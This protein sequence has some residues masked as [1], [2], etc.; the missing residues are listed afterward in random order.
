MND[1]EVTIEQA[2]ARLSVSPD[3]RVLTRIGEFADKDVMPAR[4]I[5]V[6]VLDTESTGSDAGK[7]KL[8]ELGMISMV[9][10]LGTGEICKLIDV[11]DELEDPGMPIS[12]EATAVN[13]ITND[14]V[15]GK[16]I[17]DADVERFMDGVSMVVAHNAEFDRTLV[18]KRFPL[19]KQVRWAC[20]LT[21]VD[22]AAA[23]FGSAKLEMLNL[24]IGKFYDAHRAK[25]DC[26][27]L[28]E[29]L[30]YRNDVVMPVSPMATLISVAQK[31]SF[32]I[33]AVGAPFEVKDE[34]KK[35]GYKWDA[36]KKKVW[37]K[38]VLGF[39][40][41]GAECRWLKQEIYL[42]HDVVVPITTYTSRNLF[43]DRSD[44]TERRS[45]SAMIDQYC[46]NTSDDDTSG[47]D[48]AGA[49]STQKQCATGM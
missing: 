27:A 44:A 28:I 30:A 46:A 23:G 12:A 48:N 41:L 39:D 15:A 6:V 36:V 43:T 40:A 18:E 45:L 37:H 49:I 4:S 26:R 42:G 22:W 35:N 2:L 9:V 21:Q 32:Q 14:D 16:S 7:D 19:F 47:S 20:S 34:L 33:D 5:K 29:V 31:R 10:D 1:V 38:T 8:V 25:E 24:L 13:G 11:F 17:S 3:H